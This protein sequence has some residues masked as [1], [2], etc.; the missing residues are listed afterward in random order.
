MI[1]QAQRRAARVA[2]VAFLLTILVVAIINFGITQRL[3]VPGSAAATARNILAN[4][5]AF[6]LG[7]AGNLVY[8]A[9][10]LVL[11][12]A[13]YVVLRPVSRGLALLAAVSRLVYAG[14]WILMMLNFFSALRL[15][16]GT[17]FARALGPAGSQ[18]LAH[19]YLNGYGEYYVGLLFWALA[20]VAC[21][22]LWLKSRYIPRPLAIVGLITSAWC[23]GCTLVLYVFPDFPAVVNLWW[24]DAPMALFEIVL[25]V[26]L[27][28]RGLQE[29]AGSGSVPVEARPA[30]AVIAN[31]TQ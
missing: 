6:R 10:L 31:A 11:L 17:E 9:G 19:F 30:D 25:A 27:L 5:R 2:G 20:S 26:W 1:E 24:L 8:A 28:A 4:E 22:W 21:S 15:L 14:A 7:I 12:S 13:L 23:V 18:A 16:S 29:P 3:L